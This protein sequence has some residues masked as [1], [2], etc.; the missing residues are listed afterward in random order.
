MFD[1][2]FFFLKTEI[3]EELEGTGYY[4]G[5]EWNN[6]YQYDHSLGLEKL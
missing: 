6:G 1:L 4:A 3:G 5:R 2:W